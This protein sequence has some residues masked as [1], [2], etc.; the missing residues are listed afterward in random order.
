[1]KEAHLTFGARRSTRVELRFPT[2]ISTKDP[3][4]R[5]EIFDAHTLVVSMHG[6]RLECQR[7]FQM[8]EEVGITVFTTGKSA[9]GKVTWTSLTSE[10]DRNYAFARE[11]RKLWRRTSPEYSDE[12][13]NKDSE[14]QFAVELYRPQDLWTFLVDPPQD[15]QESKIKKETESPRI[16]EPLLSSQDLVS[17]SATQQ[18][19]KEEVVKPTAESLKDLAAF[20][21]NMGPN[22]ALANLAP[23]QNNRLSSGKPSIEDLSEDSTRRTAAASSPPQVSV[24]AL[25]LSIPSV[26][27]SE[28]ANA[29]PGPDPRESHSD[30]APSGLASAPASQQ[31]MPEMFRSPQSAMAEWLADVTEII[32]S[33]LQMVPEANTELLPQSRVVRQR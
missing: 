9:K 18:P 17:E 19:Q 4:G 29:G 25:E 1:M 23:D 31:G 26:A 22:S 24:E 8:N 15:W 33:T 11:L 21:E 13:S 16:P 27:F 14:Y 28:T 10:L 5:A 2:Q 6:A 3:F 7:P 32:E 12:N 30:E 20:P